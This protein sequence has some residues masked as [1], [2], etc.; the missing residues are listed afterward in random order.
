VKKKT[1]QFITSAVALILALLFVIRFGGPSL[2]RAYVQNGIG[3]CQKIPILCL[4]PESKITNPATD[5]DFKSG[6]M[7]YSFPKMRVYLPKGFNVVQE[8]RKEFYYTRDARKFSGPVIYLLYQNPGFFPE[9]FPQLIK[10]GVT[11]NYIFISRIMAAE[12]AR[13]QN[14]TDAFFTIMKAIFTPNLGDQKNIK[15]TKFVMPGYRGYITYNL[16]KQENYFNCDI[17]DNEGG[18]FKIYIKDKG[19]RLDLDKVFTIISTA[20]KQE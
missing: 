7:L 5:E 16:E 10:Q 20:K 11:D 19:K 6:M 15:M 3:N 12:T 9:L 1:S 18:F 4:S 8:E 17:I 2:L 13:I 14:L